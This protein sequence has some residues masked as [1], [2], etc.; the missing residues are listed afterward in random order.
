MDRIDYNVEQS[1]MKTEE[2]LKQLHKVNVESVV[3]CSIPPRFSPVIKGHKRLCRNLRED[4][5]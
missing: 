4:A 1:C 3:R 5:A 2:G